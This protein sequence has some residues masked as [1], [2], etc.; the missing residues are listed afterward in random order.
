MS[1]YQGFAMSDIDNNPQADIIKKS[2]NSK[3]FKNEKILWNEIENESYYRVEFCVFVVIV[4]GVAGAELV[5]VGSA[6]FGGVGVAK[7]RLGLISPIH[8]S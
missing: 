8:D 2:S 4:V 1:N 7:V 3:S 5:D 6:Q